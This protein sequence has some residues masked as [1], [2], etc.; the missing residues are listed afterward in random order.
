MCH[1]GRP[2]GKRLILSMCVPLEELFVYFEHGVPCAVLCW[3]APQWEWQCEAVVAHIRPH[4]EG[5]PKRACLCGI[6]EVACGCLN[7]EVQYLG[8]EISQADHRAVDVRL[9][10]YKWDT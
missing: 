7:E 3:L 2:R 4:R 8:R 5:C 6:H 9:V 10:K 1:P